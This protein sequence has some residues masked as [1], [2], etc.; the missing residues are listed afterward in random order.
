MAVV[1]LAGLF[2]SLLFMGWLVW[3]VNSVPREGRSAGR[4]V[5]SGRSRAGGEK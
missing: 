5:T 4:E 1:L 3:L 2:V